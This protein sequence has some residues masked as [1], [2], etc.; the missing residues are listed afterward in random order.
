MHRSVFFATRASK[1]QLPLKKAK[2]T[3]TRHSS[4]EPDFD[5][6]VSSFKQII[7]GLVEAKILE[8]DKRENI[9]VPCYLWKKALRGHGKIT[10]RIEEI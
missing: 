6:L 8:N 4:Y 9:D 2:L 3:L 7:D 5:G 1:P 10:V